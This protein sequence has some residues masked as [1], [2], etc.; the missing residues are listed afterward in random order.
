MGNKRQKRRNPKSK[1]FFYGGMG[2]TG[3]TYFSENGIINE[4]FAGAWQ[5]NI[6]AKK[7]DALQ[8]YANFSCLTLTAN[9][10][11]KLE[12]ELRRR[13]KKVWVVD[14]TQKNRALRQLIEFPNAH[15]NSQDFLT[16]WVLSLQ[17][18]GNTFVFVD[19]EDDTPV[20]MYILDPCRVQ[21][22]RGSD[23]S[24]WYRVSADNVIGLSQ[25]F[26][27]SSREIIHHRINTF[28]DDLCGI[29]PIWA[30]A[31]H[32]YSGLEQSKTAFDFYKN[33]ARPS[34]LLIAPNDVNEEEVKQLKADYTEAMS[35][36]KNAGRIFVM[37]GG[38]QY[39]Q[40]SMSA[41]DQQLIEQM[42]FNTEAICACYHVPVYMVTGTAPTYNNVEALTQVYFQNA[43]QF[44]IQG[45]EKNLHRGLRLNELPEELWIELDTKTLLRMDKASRL[46][47]NG[48]AI[49]DGWMTPNEARADED[50]EPLNGGDTVFMQQQNYSLEALAERDKGNPLTEKKEE[51]ADNTQSVSTIISIISQVSAGV[52]THETAIAL[53]MAYFP[54]LSQKQ[55]EAIIEPIEVKQPEPVVVEEET[56]DNSDENVDN[57]DENLEKF[58]TYLNEML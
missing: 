7:D 34:G 6:Y 24:V 2:S 1:N 53:I 12:P 48:Q 41:Q 13:D 8:N 40:L 43:L 3:I 39:Q 28:F 56:I 42:R 36:R 23:G 49:K 51:E 54:T 45:I 55:I 18:K 5:H 14:E 52:I 47:S 4:P 30:A 11:A 26:T 46:K 33:A 37:S 19:W 38:V 16:R 25:D 31:I 15:Q 29:P 17:Q 27:F 35:G 22:I 21:P 57:E 58:L 9:D 50:L 32:A 44:I 10:V 20:G